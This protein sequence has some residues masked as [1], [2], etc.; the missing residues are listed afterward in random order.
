MRELVLALAVLMAGT[1]VSAAGEAIEAACRS[2][3]N[4]ASF[5]LCS[6]IQDVADATL[7]G[8]EQR[9]AATFFR[10]P[11]RAQKLRQSVLQSN[12][13]FWERYEHFAMTA[14]LLCIHL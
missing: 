13:T 4:T 5:A 14:Q 1:G 10:D 8:A 7:V 9:R 2:L 12:A 6:C 3:G 11:E